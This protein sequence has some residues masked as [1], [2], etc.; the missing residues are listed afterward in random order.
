MLVTDDYRALARY[1]TWMNERLYAVCGNLSEEERKRDRGTFF[2]SI[3][4]TLNHILLDSSTRSG[5]RRS[6]SSTTKRTTAARS[7]RSSP[8]AVKTS[9]SPTS[10]LFC[11]QKAR[12]RQ[13]EESSIIPT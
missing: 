8:S 13:R 9:A 5:S 12:R 11:A 3:H 2:R 10:R 1:N 6:T 4:G 7:R